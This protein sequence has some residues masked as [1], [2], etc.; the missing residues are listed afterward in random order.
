MLA[1]VAAHYDV[2]A[3]AV[4]VIGD[5]EH[6]AL[7]EF[8]RASAAVD[9]TGDIEPLVVAAV[10]EPRVE[11]Y[12]ICGSC[13]DLR[14]YLAERLVIVRV[15]NVAHDYSIPCGTYRVFSREY[16]GRE[17]LFEAH[18]EGKVAAALNGA[19]E[20]LWIGKRGCGGA[21]SQLNRAFADYRNGVCGSAFRRP[22]IL[23]CQVYHL[24]GIV[25]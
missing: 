22:L 10:I 7:D 25:K 19:Q 4:E 6:H 16:P 1:A 20:R 17:A 24:M 2:L 21:R 11:L 12:F 15:N 5:V 13:R 8:K 3:L 14:Y 9:L 23:C 18:R